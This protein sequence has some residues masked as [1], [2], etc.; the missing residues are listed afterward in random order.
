MILFNTL[1]AAFRRNKRRTILRGD[2]TFPEIRE[3]LIYS[4]KEHNYIFFS[5]IRLVY[6]KCPIF[7][8]GNCLLPKNRINNVFFTRAK[9]TQRRNG[10]ATFLGLHT[11]QHLHVIKYSQV[12]VIPFR[13]NLGTYYFLNASYSPEPLVSYLCLLPLRKYGVD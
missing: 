8:T 10:S 13:S 3:E 1:S 4:N 5:S 2:S 7:L 11:D 6:M 9:T 12:T